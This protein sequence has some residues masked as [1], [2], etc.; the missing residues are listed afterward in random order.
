[1]KIRLTDVVRL[2]VL[3]GLLLDC[4]RL[5][6]GDLFGESEKPVSTINQLVV[7]EGRCSPVSGRGVASLSC[8]RAGRKGEAG[9]P[10]V[11]S[12]VRLPC[13]VVV[14]CK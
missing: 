3:L 9:C 14:G 10:Q 7:Q 13:R 11:G 4:G 8:A 1:M 6:Q 2:S 5:L 12:V